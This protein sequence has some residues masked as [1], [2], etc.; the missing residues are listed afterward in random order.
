MP[1][2]YHNA[3]TRISLIISIAAQVQFD[4]DA[5]YNMTPDE[6]ADFDAAEKAKE[7]AAIKEEAA[8]E[9]EAEKEAAAVDELKANSNGTTS[10]LKG[11]AAG[12]TFAAPGLLAALLVILAVL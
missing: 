8:N 4:Y 9:E 1:R 11:S 2:T 10:E 12:R 5:Y 3:P 6:K 7:E